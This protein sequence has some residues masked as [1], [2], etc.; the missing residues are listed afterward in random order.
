[1]HYPIAGFHIEDVRA[2][3]NT[4]KFSNSSQIK[5]VYGINTAGNFSLAV[6]NIYAG[7]ETLW[8]LLVQIS[9]R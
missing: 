6:T 9:H 2:Y 5:C 4:T 1:M 3:E 7:Q 8:I